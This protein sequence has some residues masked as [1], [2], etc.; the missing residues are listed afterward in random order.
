MNNGR[1]LDYDTEAGRYD[2][3]RGGEPRAKA[4][5]TALDT[6]LPATGTVA[7]IGG[8]TGIVSRHLATPT[9][10][11]IVAD[12][13]A[14]MLTRAAT[15]LPG[16]AVRADAARLPFATG[17]LDAVTC[18]WLLHLLPP[19]VTDAVIAEAARVLAPGAILAATVNKNAAHRGGDDVD[20]IL[21]RL[22]HRGG[23]PSASD[24]PARLEA[25]TAACGLTPAG[26]VSFTGHG[27]GRTPAGLLFD[28]AGGRHLT[29]LPHLSRT[30]LDH[31]LGD[32]RALPDP[33]RPRTPPVFT[34]AAWRT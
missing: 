9:R 32:L 24:D 30:D 2:A 25:V 5:A 15:R 21:E 17:S 4:A 19:A 20:A 1:V 7:D 16:R 14:G 13:S 22:H 6:L 26:S 27:Q 12:A 34:V 10:T 8:G 23:A 18:V 11:V 33:D 31:A 28:L 3:T 29:W